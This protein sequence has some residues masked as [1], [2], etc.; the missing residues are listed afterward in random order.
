[1]SY[2]IVLLSSQGEKNVGTNTTDLDFFVNW[3]CLPN[4]HDYKLTFRFTSRLAG[5]LTANSQFLVKLVQLGTERNAY[6]GSDPTKT[7]HF[8]SSEV[9]GII[10]SQTIDTSHYLNANWSDNPSVYV[11]GRPNNNQL[12]VQITDFDGTTLYANTTM[13]WS[14][15]L[16]F[17][18]CPKKY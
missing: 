7:G 3:A 11:K 17:E 9:I 4:D 14:L 6:F 2:T 10:N 8:A 13:V 15:I 5:A 16:H 18:E 1:M 12:R